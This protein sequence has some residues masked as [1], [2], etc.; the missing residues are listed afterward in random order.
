MQANHAGMHPS[1]EISPHPDRLQR[2]KRSPPDLAI[3][4]L[5]EGLECPG[6]IGRPDPA[7]EE[8]GSAPEPGIVRPGKSD[9]GGCRRV[10]DPPERL[11]HPVPGGIVAF[12]ESLD[13]R[14]DGR[15]ADTRE[16]TAGMPPDLP[17]GV[18]ERPDERRDRLFGPHLPEHPR[19][20]PADGRP[21]VLKGGHQ[22]GS[23]RGTDTDKDRG[24][25]PP[26]NLIV[27]AE[28]PDAVSDRILPETDERIGG[29]S[30]DPL[31]GV[32]QHADQAGNATLVPRVPQ[33][34]NRA[35][36]HP[37]VVVTER[38]EEEVH[39]TA[40]PDCP[41][42]RKSTA[43]DRRVLIVRRLPQGVQRRTPDEPQR[44]GDVLPHEFVRAG[45]HPDEVRD[46]RRPCADEGAYRR[47]PDAPVLVLE[48]P[49]ER[50][51]RRL[52]D[53]AERPDRP[54]P[55]SDILA[56]KRLRESRYPGLLLCILR[57][58]RCRFLPP[59]HPEPIQ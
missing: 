53:L 48:R 4:I 42:R 27:V 11:H 25:P 29:E 9:K 18:A 17:V 32:A 28:C 50:G 41:E 36:P 1:V 22:G 21:F 58:G 49:D 6:R 33:P 56:L 7:E 3:R 24:A 40:G 23:H 37:G 26:E 35:P 57:R 59:A 10:S 13:E 16:R 34:G 12:A 5:E 43:A 8:R 44:T 30:P 38:R 39:G 31:I 20:I 14:A 15:G 47:L 46:G 54:P 2:L 52:P 51:H 19:S 45:E 55:G